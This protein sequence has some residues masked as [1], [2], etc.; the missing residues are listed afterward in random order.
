MAASALL[1]VA[2][3]NAESIRIMANVG[4]RRPRIRVA[5][6]THEDGI[7]ENERWATERLPYIVFF[8]VATTFAVLAFGR[9]GSPLERG[10]L[11]GLSAL[12]AICLFNVLPRDRSILRMA[13]S[14]SAALF[15]SLALAFVVS[16]M[17]FW[18]V[19]TGP[20]L[21]AATFLFVA[22]VTQSRLCVLGA[23]LLVGWQVHMSLSQTGLISNEALFAQG[24]IGVAFLFA[25]H[26]RW[27]VVASLAVSCFLGLA[28]VQLAAMNLSPSQTF[29]SVTILAAALALFCRTVMHVGDA[30][31]LIPFATALTAAGLAALALQLA[32]G[33]ESEVFRQS[34]AAQLVIAILVGAQLVALI[35]AITSW[36]LGRMDGIGVITQQAAFAGLLTTLIHPD[37]PQTL[38]SIEPSVG[39]SLMVG[40]V[41][42]SVGLAALFKAWSEDCPILTSVA[43]FFVVF[44]LIVSVRMLSPSFDLGLTGLVC[45]A[46]ILVIAL[47]MAVAPRKARSRSLS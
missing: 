23:F 8:C 17:N 20:M 10:A 26:R 40:S 9:L 12:S 30:R 46:G 7:A 3:D 5:D 15:A 25:L 33:P 47:I 28:L 13:L 11:C 37:W 43:G 41:V 34:S 31:S 45:A 44:Q 29:M 22:I 35:C 36:K 19:E 24:L 16:G 14:L 1:P 39:R 6:E 32:A 21:M 38:L 2:N 42:L 4:P 18:P 27:P